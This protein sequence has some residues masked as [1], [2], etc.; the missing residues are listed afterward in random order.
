LLAAKTLVFRR[1]RQATVAIPTPTAA[2]IAGEDIDR[3]AVV[4]AVQVEE[5]QW[6]GCCGGEST[7][8]ADPLDFRWRHDNTEDRNE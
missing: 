6:R 2:T 7:D 3:I 5:D 4:D 8:H 1:N